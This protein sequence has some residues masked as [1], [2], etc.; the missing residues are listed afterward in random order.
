MSGGFGP[1]SR[2]PRRLWR[3]PDETSRHY[4]LPAIA[5]GASCERGLDTGRRGQLIATRSFALVDN[6]LAIAATLSQS[7][8]LRV[9]QRAAYLFRS[10]RRRLSISTTARK[11]PSAAAISAA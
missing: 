3:T 11:L 1:L 6:I 9:L 4:A 2:P 8:P 7:L 5:L 10:L